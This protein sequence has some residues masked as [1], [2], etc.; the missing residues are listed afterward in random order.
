MSVVI[1]GDNRHDIK[2]IEETLSSIPI[3]RPDVKPYYRQ[4]LCLDK[5]YYSD[6]V[7]ELVEEF[8]YIPHIRSRGEEVKD[9]KNHPFK[10]TRR[11]V[12]ERT[13][14]WLNRFRAILIRWNKKS[15]NYL[16]FIH[17]ACALIIYKKMGVD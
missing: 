11:W 6:W 1:D 3:E 2:L 7:Y 5:G 9:L 16:A 8:E 13:H 15:I 4:H 12:V 17:F 10:K 14:S